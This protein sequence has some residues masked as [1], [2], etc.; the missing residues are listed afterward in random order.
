M[1]KRFLS[2][3]L[4]AASFGT[5]TCQPARAWWPE[6]HS[7]IAAGAV[8]ALPDEV[9]VWFRAGIGQIAHDAQDPDVQK[10]RSLAI[11]TE[12]EYPQ[13]FFDWELIGME[14]LPPTRKE[15]YA[16]CAK[17]GVSPFDVGELPYSI[18]EWT[19]RLTMA[20]AES[21]QYPGNAY[22]QNKALIYAGILS[23]YSGDATMPLH[24]TNDHDGRA[25]S[26]GSSPKTGI[27]SRV[28]SLIEKL[29]LTPDQ[30]AD[31]QTVT[32]LSA[33]WPG[34]EAQMRETYSHINQTYAMETGLPPEKGAY[35]PSPMIEAF[36]LERGRTA[37]RFTAQLFLT[38]WRDSA[39]V[40]LPSWLKR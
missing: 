23:H 13:H 10:D 7:I 17:R 39:N 36:A 35:T 31:K 26:D 33:L 19:Q 12:R 9:P 25:K 37:S 3:A 5:L 8:K 20:F 18:A 11:M 1:M 14:A 29:N 6:G 2:L 40:K 28:D 22:V 21:R 38:A 32:P 16:D 30:L 4:F 34:I 24:V 15:F 27:H